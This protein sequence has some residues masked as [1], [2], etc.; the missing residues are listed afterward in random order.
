M[1]LIFAIERIR[2]TQA[3]IE[4][5]RK[6]KTQ[7]EIFTILLIHRRSNA[8]ELFQSTRSRGGSA[9][10]K[11]PALPPLQPLQP[12][13]ACGFKFSIVVIFRSQPFKISV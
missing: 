9:A 8:F 7:K 3:N 10:L 4:P 2:F 11:E 5:N 13:G 1:L 12:R 6:A